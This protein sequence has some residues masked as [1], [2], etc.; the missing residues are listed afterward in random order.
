[1]NNRKLQKIWDEYDFD[2]E[3][4]SPDGKIEKP[5]GAGGG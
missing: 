1:M 5:V 4:E 2:I 3:V